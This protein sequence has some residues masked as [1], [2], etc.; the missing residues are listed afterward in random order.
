MCMCACFRVQCAAEESCELRYAASIIL[1][2]AALLVAVQLLQ[3]EIMRTD[4]LC[5]SAV[6]K[7][8]QRLQ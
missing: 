4:L 5:A 3:K 6:I 2:G 8:K 1:S 7:A